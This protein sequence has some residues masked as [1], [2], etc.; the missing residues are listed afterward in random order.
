M[1]QRAKELSFAGS[2][3]V[4][5][6]GKVDAADRSLV[7][8]HPLADAAFRVA[9]IREVL[10]ETGLMIGIRERA[11]AE[12]AG[13]ARK[14]LE[15]G[16]ELADVLAHFGWNL[17]LEALVPF[18]RWLPRFKAG[19][20]FDTWFYLADLGTGQVD[21]THN[22][23]ESTRLFWITAQAALQEIEEG[24]LKAIYPTRRNL[25]RLAQFQSFT[26]AVAH[27][28]SI[29][30]NPITPQ[31]EMLDGVEMLRIPLEAGYPVTVAPL[32]QIRID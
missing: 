13:E 17:D 27:A 11:Y 29:P 6:G 31:I 20:I 16:A 23:G 14:Q 28:R 7:A 4:F 10:E 12:T 30:I 2:A 1:L 25:E 22:A 15:S 19:R 18:A 26:E 24:Q 8:G 3:C 21:L 32:A 5:P 9:A